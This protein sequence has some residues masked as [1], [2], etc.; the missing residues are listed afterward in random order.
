MSD[1]PPSG[2]PGGPPTGPPPG[3]PTAEGPPSGPPTA[4][5]PPSGP[6]KGP[7]ASRPATAG[8]PTGPPSGPSG[9]PPTS[10]PAP[11]GPGRSGGG[12]GQR[13]LRPQAIV[14]ILA[15]LGG[16]G[17]LATRGGG[18]NGAAPTPTV[19]VRGEVLREPV[20]VPGPGPF[21]Q[22]VSFST[23][24]TGATS[25]TST[26]S[27]TT[28]APTAASTTSGPVSIA[29]TSGATPGLYGGTLKNAECNK[30][31]LV[32]F[33]EANPDKAKAW[34]DVQQIQPAQIRDYVAKLTPAT[35]TADTR[36]TNHGFANGKATPHQSVL[37]KG[38]AVLVDAFGAPRARCYCGNPLIPAVAQADAA[39]FTGPSWP[40]F[41]PTNLQAISPSPTPLT[42]LQLRDNT[43][44]A[45]I[46]RPVGSDGSTDASTPAPPTLAEPRDRPAPTVVATSSTTGVTTTAV[47]PTTTLTNSTTRPALIAAPNAFIQKEGV[48]KATSVY[49][50]TYAPSNAID[51][52]RTTSW[53][54]KGSI[55]DGP[56]TTYTWT[57]TKDDLITLVRVIGNGANQ[58]PSIRSNFG[59]GSVIIR[60]RDANGQ[61]DFEQTVPL[62]GTPDPDAVVQ[63]GVRGRSVEL[64]FSGGE[65][66]DCGGFAEL[67]VGVT[68]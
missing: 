50:A 3:P 61:I 9:G 54:S 52:D 11:N 31:Q 8:P 27:T 44:N 58:D 24:A 5:G 46:A 35:L 51:G 20:T 6:P 26:T 7:T 14:G 49:S 47:R 16:G 34:A 33:L 17:F 19:S 36:V 66:P 1:G 30:E 57:G 60:V 56:T 59:F 2:P 45:G 43:R 65:T 38:T 64:V 10:T 15:L 40:A 37:Q 18:G 62:P 42:V 53:F 12:I 68:R 67:E 13:L 28:T 48:V 63:P 25:T 32:M 41:D 4:G 55:V 39:S 29:A 22:P 21:T 23:G